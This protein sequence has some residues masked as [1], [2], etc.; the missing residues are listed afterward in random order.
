[1][2]CIKVD[3]DKTPEQKSLEAIFN[4]CVYSGL[5]FNIVRSPYFQ[6]MIDAITLCGPGYIGPSPKALKG[7]ILVE[8]IQEEKGQP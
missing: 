3:D 4:F 5:D 6:A 7:M 1:M 2:K 8:A